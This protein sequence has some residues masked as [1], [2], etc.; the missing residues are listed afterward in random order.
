MRFPRNKLL[1]MQQ[2]LVKEKTSKH[3]LESHSMFIKNHV[4]IKIPWNIFEII[5]QLRYLSWML[6]TIK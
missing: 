3:I 4:N 2:T 5:F 6:N 1:L